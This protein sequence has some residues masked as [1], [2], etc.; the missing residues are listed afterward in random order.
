ML[1]RKWLAVATL[2]LGTA[3][4]PVAALAQSSL[5][6]QLR[7]GDREAVLAALSGANVDAREPDGS[8]L[9]LWATY[10][11]DRDMVRALLTAGAD[12]SVT[13]NYGSTPLAEAVKLAD[14]ELV[15]MLLD[16]GAN[17]DAPNLDNQTALMLAAHLGKLDIASLLI[18]RGAKVNAVENFRGQNALMWAAAENHPDVVELLV[19]HGADVHPRAFHDDWPRQMTSEPRAQFRATGGLTAL[20][21]ATRSG[22]YRCVVAIVEAGADVNRPNP[23]G[24]TPL[25]NAIDAKNFDIAMYLIDKGANVHVWDMHGRTPF[26]MAIDMNSFRGGGAGAFGGGMEPAPNQRYAAM[27]VA[28]RLVSMGVDVNHELT[29]MRPNGPGRGRFAD[30]M[31]RGGTGPLMV[32]ALSNDHEAIEFLLQNGAEADLY[33]VFRITPLMAAVG[34]SGTGRANNPGA[35]GDPQAAAIKSVDLFLAAGADINRQVTDSHTLTARLD[36]YVAWKD[37]EGRT[38]LH[39]AAEAGLD[40]L[41]AHLLER[42]ADPTIVDAK[43]ANALDVALAAAAT[44][45]AQPDYS[46]QA[47]ASRDATIAALAAA[48]GVDP[49]A[50]AANAE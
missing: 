44:A 11:A 4:L 14:I 17:A 47:K 25:L 21:Y 8:T 13:N 30:Y 38:A 49:V 45:A 1:M 19:S 32:A 2:S 35:V 26:Y 20:L 28:R 40:R 6:D 5:V 9:L 18:E 10:Q 7:A 15:R 12:P 43:G 3:A 39:N 23:D 22:C 34:M 36:T 50:V 31:M 42:G 37:N 29:R 41:V 27:D 46:A 33:N 24:I 48:L 16:A